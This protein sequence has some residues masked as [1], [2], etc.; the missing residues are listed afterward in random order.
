MFKTFQSTERHNTATQSSL[1][2]DWCGRG[3]TQ[4]LFQ[5]SQILNIF[6]F[7]SAGKTWL[8][9]LAGWTRNS[10]QSSAGG[11]FRFLFWILYLERQA[12]MYNSI[13][14]DMV[15][16]PVS[17]VWLASFSSFYSFELNQ[18]EKIEDQMELFL[19]YARN[20]G[21]PQVFMQTKYL[22]L[23]KLS[24]ISGVSLWSL[25]R[26][27]TIEGYSQS[28]KMSGTYGKNGRKYFVLILKRSSIF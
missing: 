10:G 9:S 15:E 7:F 5:H 20:F 24:S 14:M 13:S 2:D 11:K 22:E 23:K 17:K 21:V 1:L 8:R 6:K 18:V 25:W 3:E 16:G 28:Y 19:E 12:C 26:L 27:D 4:G